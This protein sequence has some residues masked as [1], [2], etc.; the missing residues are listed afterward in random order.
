MRLHE[1]LTRA[2]LPNQLVTVPGG[3]HGGFTD[4]ESVRIYTAIRN[5]LSQNNIVK[6]SQ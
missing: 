4:D 3:K 5:F 1:G 2:D 6:T